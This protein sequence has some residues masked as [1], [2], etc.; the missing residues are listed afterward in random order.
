MTTIQ[1]PLDFKPSARDAVRNVVA[2]QSPLRSLAILIALWHDYTWEEVKA[3]LDSLLKA[4][5]I[6]I[7]GKYEPQPNPNV[8]H[9]IS[10]EI[11]RLKEA[12]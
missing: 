7:S 6:E 5:E 10:D 2:K 1:M 8:V 3:A 11:Y 4:G 9:G 12:A